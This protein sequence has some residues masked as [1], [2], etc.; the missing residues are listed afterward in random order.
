[1]KFNNID[2]IFTYSFFILLCL[3]CGIL[4]QM[5]FI[6]IN[7]YSSYDNISTLKIIEFG[8]G[9]SYPIIVL[10]IYYYMLKI[11]ADIFEIKIKQHLI[12]YII[13]GFIP[14]LIF[15]ITN[16]YYLNSITYESIHKISIENGEIIPGIDFTNS[17]YISSM[18]L[19]IPLFMAIFV[20]ERKDKFLNFIKILSIPLSIIAV[21]EIISF[22]IAKNLSP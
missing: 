11:S 12:E 4:R 21:F 10:V 19:T 15:I 2:K 13:I 18:L 8:L 7:L 16:I 20:L 3:F 9:F 17:K 1:M 6:K 22:Y 14:Y 5:M